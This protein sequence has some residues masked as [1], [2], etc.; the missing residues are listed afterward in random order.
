MDKAS[1]K[2]VETIRLMG[3]RKNEIGAGYRTAKST[4][5]SHDLA[6]NRALRTV[7]IG[8]KVKWQT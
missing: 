4:Y 1:R 7:V 2:R 3:A 8:E 6:V 5:S